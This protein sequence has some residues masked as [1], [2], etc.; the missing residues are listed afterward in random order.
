VPAVAY[1][2]QG[3]R[4][5]RG[6]GYYD[7]FIK[8]QS[9]ATLVGVGYDFQLVNEVPMLLHDQKVQYVITPSQTIVV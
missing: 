2:K 8:K 3:H 1:D 6:G 9:H 5:G 7:R 4:L